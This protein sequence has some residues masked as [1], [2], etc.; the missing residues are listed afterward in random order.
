MPS[1]SLI[2]KKIETYRRE[3]GY[4][5][6]DNKIS[7]EFFNCYME[8]INSGEFIKIWNIKFKT[9][10]FVERCF[11][12]SLTFKNIYHV[13]SQGNC[14]TSLYNFTVKHLVPF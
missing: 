13:D 4:I 6:G 7:T 1:W 10:K 2:N 11:N 9:A 12:D 8:K 3:L 14:S 5:N